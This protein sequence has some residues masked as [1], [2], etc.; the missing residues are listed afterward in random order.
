M[1]SR[2]AAWLEVALLVTAAGALGAEPYREI[3]RWVLPI[4]AG[5]APLESLAPPG[6]FPALPPGARRSTFSEMVPLAY[7]GAPTPRT[8]LVVID[9]YGERGSPSQAARSL[10]FVPGT[11]APMA[12][13]ATHPPPPPPPEPTWPPHD[14]GGGDGEDDEH[15]CEDPSQDPHDRE[16]DRGGAYRLGDPGWRP[17]NRAPP[18]GPCHD[19]HGEKDTGRRRSDA[20]EPGET[21][22]AWNLRVRKQRD[23]R[24]LEAMAARRRRLT[25]R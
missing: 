16:R 13:P 22:A 18:R 17:G 10:G 14:D 12:P 4:P 1:A 2:R 8:F 19:A 23:A 3:R 20:R 5:G 6:G 21:L 11:T 15:D 7:P 9:H 25:G 24:R